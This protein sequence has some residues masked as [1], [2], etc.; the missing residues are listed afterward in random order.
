[1]NYYE[2]E[3]L[4]N[5]LKVGQPLP[6]KSSSS[7][8]P[9]IS[10]RPPSVVSP[11]TSNWRTI[12]FTKSCS[13]RATKASISTSCSRGC[14][15]WKARTPR[16]GARKRTF[17]TTQA[18][19]SEKSPS[20]MT[21]PEGLQSSLTRTAHLSEFP[22]KSSINAETWKN[23]SNTSTASLKTTPTSRYFLFHSERRQIHD[24]NRFFTV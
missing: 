9:S 8:N 10:P 24:P 6:R 19:P 11:P 15:V 7:R 5:I 16:T 1:M 14:I 13:G 2:R 21:F 23:Q 4:I 18:I 3:L 12:R 20:Y 17:T 22:S